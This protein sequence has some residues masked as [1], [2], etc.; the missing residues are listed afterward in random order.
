MPDE[1]VIKK[2]IQQAAAAV[3]TPLG[4]ERERERERDEYINS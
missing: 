3:Q 4:R 2:M 1:S